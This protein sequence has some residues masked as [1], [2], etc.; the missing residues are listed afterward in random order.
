MNWFLD[1]R[2]APCHQSIHLYS[3]LNFLL[4]PKLQLCLRLM[5][6]AMCVACARLCFA[7]PGQDVVACRINKA[8]VL[9]PGVACFLF[10]AITGLFLH[11]SNM[12]DVRPSTAGYYSELLVVCSEVIYLLPVCRHHRPLPARL[13][14]GRYAPQHSR[15]L[16]RAAGFWHK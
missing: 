16:F 14:R 6:A 2:W 11:A 13:Q 7:Q 8:A 4:I 9:F 15:V 3:C 5:Q 12:D 10:A 1:D